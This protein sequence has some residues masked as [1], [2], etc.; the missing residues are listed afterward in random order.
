MAYPSNRPDDAVRFLIDECL[1]PRLTQLVYE[2]GYVGSH[3]NSTGLGGQ[4]DR[5][6][7]NFAVEAGRILVTNNARDYR[8]IYRTFNRHPGLIV[9]LP[10][11]SA[12]RQIELMTRV[13]EFIEREAIIVDQLVQIDRSGKITVAEWVA[14]DGR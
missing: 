12:A 7:A 9:I 3:V 11:A 14:A 4:T 2:H 6:V 8:S 1:T 10:S 13:L 5:V